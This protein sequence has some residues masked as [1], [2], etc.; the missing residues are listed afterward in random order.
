MMTARFVGALLFGARAGLGLWGGQYLEPDTRLYLG[1][2]GSTWFYPSPGGRALGEL[3]YW[4]L[5]AVNVAA[6]FAL[7]YVVV[8]LAQRVGTRGYLAP[9]VCMAFPAA[10]YLQP[11]ALDTVGALLVC[12]AVLLNGAGLGLSSLL[13]HPASGLGWL[14]WWAWR[15][16]IGAVSTVTVVAICGLAAAMMTPYAGIITRAS[17]AGTLPALAT[18]L[19]VA[20]P[21]GLLLVCGYRF[22]AGAARSAGLWSLAAGLVVVFMQGG[23]QVRY[24]LPG[25]LLLGSSVAY[26]RGRVK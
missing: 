10:W 19:T 21:V 12:S 26:G 9:W 16:G 3:G 22:A 2:P 14:G 1:G 18:G 7:G 6:A 20:I 17:A 15:G 25:C 5:G 24:L 13:L 8:A 4:G 11:V 23:I